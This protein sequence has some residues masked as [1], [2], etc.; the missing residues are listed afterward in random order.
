MTRVDPIDRLLLPFERFVRAQA[1]G[2]VLLL[3][4]AV[5]A[6]V[7]ANSPWREAYHHLWEHEIALRFDDWELA[8]SLHHWINDGLMAMFFFVVGLELKRELVGGELARP[9]Q[10]LLPVA[11]GIGGMLV[12]AGIYLLV[13]GGERPAADGWGI[14][15][16]T[17][18]A[19]AVGLIALLGPRVPTALKVFLTTLAIAD[20]LGA[21]P[22]IALF[23]TSDVSLANLAI[24]GG[25]LAV[26]VAGNV[27]GVRSPVF[28]GL[29]GI[30]GLW[31]A[32]LLSGVH[33]TIAGV[34]AAMTIPASVKI[35]EAGYVRRMRRSVDEFE[36]LD[37]NDVPT[38]T[39]E[40][41]HTVDQAIRLARHAATPLQQ[42]EHQLHPFVA[43]V[44]M[45]LF[46]LANAGVE[47]P[48]E[49]GAALSAP[50]ALGVALGL[51][52]G[53]PVG[54]LLVCG[55][56][57]R[58]GLARLGADFGWR[59]LVGVAFLAGIGFTMSLFVNALA[60][61]SAEL[62]EQAKLGILLASLVAGGVGFAILRGAAPPP[63]GASSVP[64]ATHREP[65]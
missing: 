1:S 42:L 60:F 54:I 49:I 64:N 37:P 29:F 53:K 46:A 39:P 5:V 50:V 20:D 58:L 27:L 26:L 48:G 11:A 44:V 7:C 21:V 15:M 51:L 61:E 2:G 35:D 57:D 47:L 4:A 65:S 43:F 32:F 28:Y 10:A 6:M 41:L 24:G 40:Q 59:P 23:Y 18:I 36:R 56:F 52:V 34:L 19:F 55:L 8:G 9:A 63:G 33:A 30:G 13:N 3:V 62:R 25:F 22:V 12:P 17:D 45:P 14:P 38:L 16:A 31:V